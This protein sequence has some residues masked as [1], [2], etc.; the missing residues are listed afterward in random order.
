MGLGL[1][2]GK[3]FLGNVSTIP[4]KEAYGKMYVDLI[5]DDKTRVVMKL[6][7]FG[8]KADREAHKNP[9]KL[10]RKDLISTDAAFQKFFGPIGKT[11]IPDG[12]KFDGKTLLE[13]QAYNWL[14]NQPD[15]TLQG[16]IPG[17]WEN[18]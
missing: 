14:K 18:N 9:V 5:G 12:Q 6:E 7:I 16:F 1:K 13:H 4:L 17:D 11:N 2:E 8:T 10:W 3:T 15:N